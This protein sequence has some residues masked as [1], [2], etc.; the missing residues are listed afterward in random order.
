MRYESKVFAV[1]LSAAL[2][3]GMFTFPVAAMGPSPGNSANQNSFSAFGAV[4]AIDTTTKPGTL[5]VALDGTSRLLKADNYTNFT[6]QLG[7]TVT[8]TGMMVYGGV[9]PGGMMGPNG[10]TLYPGRLTLA[11]VQTEDNVFIR[12]YLDTNTNTYIVSQIMIWLY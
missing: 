5:T 1:I 7:K 9:G 6:F 8:V 10:M 3:M 11:D 2:F 12:G 4:F